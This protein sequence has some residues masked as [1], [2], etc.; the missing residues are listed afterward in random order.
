MSDL[1]LG[2]PDRVLGIQKTELELFSVQH[3]EIKWDNNSSLLTLLLELGGKPPPSLSWTSRSK[4][5]LRYHRVNTTGGLAD[6][7]LVTHVISD[8]RVTTTCAS[9]YESLT[10]TW[11][12]FKV[13]L[14][15]IHLQHVQDILRQVIIVLNL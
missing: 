5:Y 15:S 9:H 2:Y 6:R 1:E 10:T 14:R 13:L 4:E 7:N 3:S 8:D 12:H 11:T